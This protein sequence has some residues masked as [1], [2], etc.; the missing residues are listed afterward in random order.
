MGVPVY[1]RVLIG[2]EVILRV[3]RTTR[4]AA[5]GPAFGGT[6][7]FLGQQRRTAA[8]RGGRIDDD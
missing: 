7:L 6:K 1:D 8:T 5:S 4:P 3:I 2:S